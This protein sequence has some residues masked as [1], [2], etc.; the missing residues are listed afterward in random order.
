MSDNI[1]KI[2]EFPKF[3][4]S[5][6]FEYNLELLKSYLLENGTYTEKELQEKI[7]E[8]AIKYKINQ[9]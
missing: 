3:E 1:E 9:N 6:G 7:K 2:V 8:L 4:I 5:K